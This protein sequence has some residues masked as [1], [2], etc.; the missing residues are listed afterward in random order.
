[1][2][3]RLIRYFPAVLSGLLLTAAFPGINFYPAAFFALVPILV[4]ARG[5]GA[6][7][8]FKLGIAAGICHF[9]TLLYWITP[10]L[11]DYGGI[12]II[13]SASI[14]FLLCLYLSL[15]TGLF[16]LLSGRFSYK[17][18]LFPFKAAF[19]W[20]ALEYAR[21]L[22]LTGFPWGNAGYSQYL[23]LQFIQIAD[24][25][26]VFGV[27][28]LILLVNG[29]LA[30]AYLSIIRTD[31]SIRH[32]VTPLVF[33]LAG[34]ILLLLAVFQYGNFR[35]ETVDTAVRTAE[36]SKI[37]VIQGNIRQNLKWDK[38]YIEKTLA[39]YTELSLKAAR[40]NPDPSGW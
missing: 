12:H 40:E 13:L 37:S 6:A 4:S 24:I 14:L 25:T 34:T 16:V 1:M 31:L 10:T 22:L 39:T 15:Y 27:S 18:P 11:K 28:F 29:C 3:T 30:L 8:R 38:S 2:V 23:N 21:S 26:G 5:A 32:R 9:G 36:Q 7:E 17:S 19:L 35:M 33:P 20:T